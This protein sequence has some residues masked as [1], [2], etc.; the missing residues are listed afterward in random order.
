MSFDLHDDVW[1]LSDATLE[2]D[3]S[4]A[5][6]V[7]LRSWCEKN[8]HIFLPTAGCPVTQ[9]RSGISTRSAE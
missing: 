5:G 6:K 8:K 9:R 3:E 1:L 4:H 7:V 2:K